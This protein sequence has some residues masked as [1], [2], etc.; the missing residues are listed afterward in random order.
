MGTLRGERRRLR[1]GR[2][3]RSSMGTKKIST[4]LDKKMCPFWPFQ[5]IMSWLWDRAIA[6]KSYLRMKFQTHH[7]RS[8]VRCL[9]VVAAGA[10]AKRKSSRNLHLPRAKSMIATR[11]ALATVRA[12][13][14]P[15]PLP[16]RKMMIKKYFQVLIKS[17]AMDKKM[18]HREKIMR[19][20]KKWVWYNGRQRLNLG[21]T[22]WFRS[23]LKFSMEISRKCPSYW[24]QI[25]R[26]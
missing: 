9:S 22:W 16:W 3:I 23:L 8:K 11:T 1:G 20:M 7:Q 12:V 5:L 18:W 19:T 15:M 26:T 6:S 10:V 21:W 13:W 17:W 25:W 4:I 2:S 24:G 14:H